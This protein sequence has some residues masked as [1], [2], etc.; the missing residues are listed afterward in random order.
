MR[1][2]L[3]LT[4]KASMSST[5]ED[6]IQNCEKAMADYTDELTNMIHENPEIDTKNEWSYVWRA[7]EIDKLNYEVRLWR[8][9]LEKL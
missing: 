6:R 1:K 3:S 5:I 8:D 7:E 9:I 4:V 2:S